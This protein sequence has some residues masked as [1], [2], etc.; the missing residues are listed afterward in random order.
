MKGSEAFHEA[1]SL[2]PLPMFHMRTIALAS[3]LLLGFFAQTV[4]GFDGSLFG[5]LTGRPLA[6]YIAYVADSDSQQDFPRAVPR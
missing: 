3:C 4:N 1:N 2:E 5:G 6:F